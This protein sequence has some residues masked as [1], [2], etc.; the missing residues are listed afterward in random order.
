MQLKQGVL[1]RKMVYSKENQEFLD[2]SLLCETGDAENV[3]LML[4]NKKL[5]NDVAEMEAL[6][7]DVLT[8]RDFLRGELDIQ[9]AKNQV[10]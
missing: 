5:A 7:N 3:A 8:E 9:I 2:P 10:E 4:Q 1:D 6:Y